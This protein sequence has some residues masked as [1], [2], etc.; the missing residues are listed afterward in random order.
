MASES[1]SE[2]GEMITEE[3]KRFLRA[4]GYSHLFCYEVWLPIAE[5]WY[6]TYLPVTPDSVEI[7]QQSCAARMQRGE[8]QHIKVESL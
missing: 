4:A 8:I 6:E 2:S 3:R 1:G 5:T 7:N